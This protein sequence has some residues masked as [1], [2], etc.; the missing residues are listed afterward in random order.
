MTNGERICVVTGG[1]AGIGF[2]IA[3]G[4]L[5]SGARV[6]SIDRDGN[7]A[8]QAAAASIGLGERLSGYQADLSSQAEVR[9]VAA[10]IRA[11]CPRVDVL[12]NNAGRHI[13]ARETSVDGLEMNF[14]LNCLAGFQLTSLLLPLLRAAPEARIV[15]LASEAHRVPG[16]FKLDD[17]NTEKAPMAHAYGKSKFGVILWS[18]ALARELRAEGIT[19]NAVCPGLVATG[20]FEN[21]VPRWVM[22]LSRLASRLGLM[23]TPAQGARLPLA[24][25]L[26]PEYATTTGRFSGSHSIMRHVPEKRGTDDIPLQQAFIRRLR[27]IAG[28]A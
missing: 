7:P 6:V 12:I 8:L 15:N 14:A 26:S 13:M 24:L 17:L 10:R 2:H 9:A 19:V 20:I 18:K 22:P 5:R 25:A 27:E 1:N 3:L 16:H 28:L 23:S 4:L 11:D 21:F